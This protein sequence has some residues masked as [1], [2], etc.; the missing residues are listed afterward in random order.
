MVSPHDKE[1]INKGK[2]EVLI[3]LTQSTS[4]ALRLVALNL[5]A[6]LAD[7]STLGD[8]QGL[9]FN[10]PVAHRAAFKWLTTVDELLA[11]SGVHI[12]F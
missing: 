10:L 9:A 3:R 2:L 4:E 6:A 12:P 8:Q 5:E 1:A 7:P 11:S